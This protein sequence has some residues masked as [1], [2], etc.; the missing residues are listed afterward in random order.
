MKVLITGVTGMLG[1]KIYEIFK[2]NKFTVLGV[3]RGHHSQVDSNELV[4]GDLTS[5]GFIDSLKYFNPDIVIHTAAN[6]NVNFC[7]TNKQYTD[8][9]HI[10]SSKNIS[11]I[12][13][14][15]KIVYISTDSVF[16]GNNGMF[17]ESSVVNPANYYA[18]TKLRGE[19]EV[20]YNNSK[21]YI[22]R[23]NIY[24]YHQPIGNSLF[25][26]G[27]TNIKQNN[28]VKGFKNVYF[29]PL[30][31]GQIAGVV[32]QMLVKQ[33]PFGLYH[34]ACDEFLSKYDFLTKIAD[35]FNLNRTLIEATDAE[36]ATMGVFRPLNTTLVN[37]KIKL[38]LPEFD[39]S[40]DSGLSQLYTDFNK[41]FFN[42]KN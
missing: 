32:Y 36:S 28:S 33:I 13:N 2:K 19:N 24:G 25:E 18:L 21:S 10:E 35:R 40:L 11:Q 34:L 3:A 23:L 14:K 30:Y 22:L 17:D 42:E 7:E 39:F 16:S 20:L 29:N 37:R 8:L 27:L 26:W 6:V 9:L 15:A 4:I 38:A 12:F 1:L 5:H 31:S 41:D